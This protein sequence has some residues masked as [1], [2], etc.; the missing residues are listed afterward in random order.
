MTSWRYWSATAGVQSA[1]ASIDHYINEE[2][3]VSLYMLWIQHNEN[4]YWMKGYNVILATFF[5]FK[6]LFQTI[7][8]FFACMDTQQNTKQTIQHSAQNTH[9]K[10]K[11][12]K[13][14]K[15][16]R[17][18]WEQHWESKNMTNKLSRKS[19]NTFL[20]ITIYFDFDTVCIFHP[21][22]CGFYDEIQILIQCSSV[23]TTL[24]NRFNI[25]Q[26]VSLLQRNKQQNNK[27]MNQWRER[28]R[29]GMKKKDCEKVRRKVT[30][31]CVSFPHK[32][33]SAVSIAF[34]GGLLKCSLLS[35]HS[36]RALNNKTFILLT[37]HNKLK[38]SSSKVGLL[39]CCCC[40]KICYLKRM[41]MMSVWGPCEV[42]AYWQNV[43]GTSRKGS[44]FSFSL[45]SNK[46]FT[47]IH[48]IIFLL[49]L[50]SRKRGNFN[51]RKIFQSQSHFNLLCFWIV[52]L[53]VLNWV[54]FFEMDKILTFWLKV[55][56]YFFTSSKSAK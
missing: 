6:E 42:L 56:K 41:W 47:Y 38:S 16:K 18:R 5:H 17:N 28:M 55:S 36:S 24:W 10:R 11:Q 31:C 53:G 51:K 29:W 21:K 9:C 30:G 54:V 15:T 1:L 40:F 14:H 32:S 39:N 13:E 43:E 45:S 25:E 8:N 35:S 34:R 22:F 23:K 48:T 19:G 52:V 46:E 49:L 2:N 26:F 4:T 33:N 7:K 20:H 44:Y 27:E 50:W 37:L 12:T 3:C